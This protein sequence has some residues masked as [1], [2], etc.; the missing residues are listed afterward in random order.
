MLVR[1]LFDFV[2]ITGKPAGV[3]LYICAIP[4]TF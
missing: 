4:I 2:G 1:R 3:A